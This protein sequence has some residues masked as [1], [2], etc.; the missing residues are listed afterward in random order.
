MSF[1][2]QF[3]NYMDL[4]SGSC[5]FLTNL[6]GSHCSCPIWIYNR[7]YSNGIFNFNFTFSPQFVTE[8]PALYKTKIIKKTTKI[9]KFHCQIVEVTDFWTLP[10]AEG[11][12]T[13]ALGIPKNESQS[14]RWIRYIHM[15]VWSS[16]GC[17]LH[18]YGEIKE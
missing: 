13:L 5:A 15:Y 9:K 17:K 18:Y 4:L 3:H 14:I 1:N 2:N 12:T 6:T 10:Y 16:G 7:Y 8:W 11:Y